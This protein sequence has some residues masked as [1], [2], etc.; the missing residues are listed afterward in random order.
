MGATEHVNV[1][2]ILMCDS[3]YSMTCVFVCVSSNSGSDSES[4]FK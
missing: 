1:C 3:V 4:V 2:L